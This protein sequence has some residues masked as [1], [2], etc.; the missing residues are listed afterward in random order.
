MKLPLLL[1]VLLCCK[2]I[3]IAMPTTAKSAVL[4]AEMVVEAIGKDFENGEHLEMIFGVESI[5]SKLKQV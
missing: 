5:R 1:L 3:P 4:I 2:Y